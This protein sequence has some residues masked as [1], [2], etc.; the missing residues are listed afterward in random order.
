MKEAG[1]KMLHTLWFP[2]HDVL[3]KENSKM[4]NQSV[5]DRDQRQERGWLQKSVR[6]LFGGDANVL[7]LVC[8]GDGYVTGNTRQNS[9]NGSSRK[10]Q[11]HF[12]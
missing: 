12:M 11:F 9:L 4:K 6:E 8:G 1:Y 3:E 7:Y 5:V 2:L 10:E